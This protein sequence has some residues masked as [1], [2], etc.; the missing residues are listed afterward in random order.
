MSIPYEI[1]IRGKA[2]AFQGAHVIEE[3]GGDARPVTADDLAALGIAIDAGLLAR[4]AELEAEL[5]SRG[6]SFPGGLSKLTLKRRLD[7]L[8]KW[9]AFKSF[10]ASVGADEEFALAS[11]IRQ[12]DPMF[13]QLAPAA[14][15]ALGLGDEEMKAL[16]TP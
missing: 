3:S 12:S 11:E 13:Q 15:Q 7:G 1:L 2:G 9:R 5:A 4:V 6:A 10:L 14:Q 16:L 8:G